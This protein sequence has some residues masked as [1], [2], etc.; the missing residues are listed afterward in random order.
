MGRTLQTP[1]TPKEVCRAIEDG[2]IK[3]RSLQECALSD[4]HLCS[5]NRTGLKGEQEDVCSECN[6]PVFFTT[7]FPAGKQP[8][9]VC[10]K[11]ALEITR[12]EQ[13]VTE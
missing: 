1:M 9:K 8:R 3:V 11:C 2:R 13:T 6:R 5:N 7:V 4:L 10:V 12:G